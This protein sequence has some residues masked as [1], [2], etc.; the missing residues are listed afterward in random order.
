[1]HTAAD[2]RYLGLAMSAALLTLI[3]FI[4]LF[5]CLTIFSWPSIEK[6]GLSFLWREQWNPVTGEFGAFAAILGTLVTSIIAI[7]LAI[8]ISLGIA[9][10]VDYLTPGKLGLFFARLIE[11]MAGIPSI[12]YG[13]W[14]LFVLLPWMQQLQQWLYPLSGNLEQYFARLQAD[15]SFW[16]HFKPV[17][18][19]F[20]QAMPTGSCVLAGAL[21]LTIMVVPLTSSVIR[22]VI[23]EVP[24]LTKEAAYG[25]GATRWEV[26]RHV[27][28]PRSKRGIFGAF[29]LGFGRALGE[30]MAITFV[31]GNTHAL[32][33]LFMPSTTISASIANE[34]TEATG[35]LYPAALVETGL[36]L[37]LITLAVLGLSRYILNREKG[38]AT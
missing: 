20:V 6:F 12:I 21:I 25:L 36:L 22:D 27:I 15:G 11:V 17:V 7:M 2:K 3:V 9:F 4:L 8:P 38:A 34:F 13:I 23:S 1:M 37:F 16:A 26:I 5:I 31:I 18:M 29:V 10:L 28:L 24:A 35:T 14:G 32:E 33:G 30:T 19:F